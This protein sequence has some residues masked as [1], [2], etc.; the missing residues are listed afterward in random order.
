MAWM[1]NNLKAVRKAQGLKQPAIALV[2]GVS[3]GQVS[4][5]ESGTDNV[6]SYRLPSFERAYGASLSELFGTDHAADE[7]PVV[8]Y[9]GAGAAIYAYDDL[10]QGEGYDFVERP[11]FVKGR[12]I[13]VEVKGDSLFPTA[14]D[15]WRLIYTGEQTIIESEVL[16]KLCVVKLIDG[17]TL[18]KRL[19]RGSSPARYHL[20]STNAP[21]IEDAEIEWAAK[22]KAIIPK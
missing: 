17:R 12:A 4:R 10:P 13:A 3:V 11:E 21:P 14:E 18:V 19:V 1:A 8:G 7:L 9:V 2:L 6:P 16:N 5:W 15:G 20:L 22:V